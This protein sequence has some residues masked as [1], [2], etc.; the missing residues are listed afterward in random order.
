MVAIAG[1]SGAAA[2]G[3]GGSNDS[4]DEDVEREPVPTY[5][6]WCKDESP[7]PLPPPAS[8]VLMLP[9]DVLGLPVCR[10][11]S[12]PCSPPCSLP[13]LPAPAHTHPSSS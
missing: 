13:L 10:R 1:G 8:A 6:D 3:G 7:L 12:P 4:G 5:S 2:S 9:N 11:C